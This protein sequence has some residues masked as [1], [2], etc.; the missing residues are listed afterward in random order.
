MKNDNI[1]CMVCGE[2]IGPKILKCK[3]C[4]LAHKEEI[5]RGIEVIG[6]DYDDP[7]TKKI[8]KN[9]QQV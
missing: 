7:D 2:I 3:S 5:E 4:G 1:P 8:V 6:I 9:L